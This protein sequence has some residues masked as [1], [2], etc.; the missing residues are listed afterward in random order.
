MAKPICMKFGKGEEKEGKYMLCITLK[1][2]LVCAIHFGKED[3]Y[4]PNTKPN[5][6]FIRK[7][8][9]DHPFVAVF[10]YR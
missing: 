5:T 1:N 6:S 2:A 7:M 3:V 9:F 4:R 8:N 10:Q